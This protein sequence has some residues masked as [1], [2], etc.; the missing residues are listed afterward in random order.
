LDTDR[1][2]W[3]D[4]LRSATGTAYHVLRLEKGDPERGQGERADVIQKLADA[5]RAG[6]DGSDSEFWRAAERMAAFTGA[7]PWH[8]QR[9]YLDGEVKRWKRAA[10]AR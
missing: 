4:E 9:D 6:W 3:Y 7:M 10:R 5:R 8:P 2:P 1:P